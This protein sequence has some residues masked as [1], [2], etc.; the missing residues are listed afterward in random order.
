MPSPMWLFASKLDP[1]SSFTINLGPLYA[2]RVFDRCLT[3]EGIENVVRMPAKERYER[4]LA[5]LKSQIP[6]SNRV[7]YTFIQFYLGYFCHQLSNYLPERVNVLHFRE[8]ALCYYQ[9]FLEI[10]SNNDEGRYYAQWQTGM[11]QDS[12][13][14]PWPQCESSL[15]KANLLDPIRGEAI[16]K[17]IQH[18]IQKRE[19]S[20]AYSYS[21]SAVNQFLDKRPAAKRRWFIDFDAYNRNVLRT[22]FDICQ[23][24][25]NYREAEITFSKLLS[26]KASHRDEFG[27]IEVRQLHNLE[28]K[29]KLPDAA[30]QCLTKI[31]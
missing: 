22:H 10:A 3:L 25:G 11:L 23:S 4:Y 7:Q 1:F 6:K 19:W 27:S 16:R 20:T 9:S 18:Y 14:Y 26:Y 29:I 24:L 21:A 2:E 30:D 31:I 12:L 17:I 5:W 28:R 15:L 13:H 8:K